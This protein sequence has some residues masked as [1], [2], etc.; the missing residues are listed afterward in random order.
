MKTI[1]IASLYIIGMFVYMIW[2]FG[3]K[4]TLDYLY[5]ELLKRDPDY[6]RM[7]EHAIKLAIFAAMLLVS[8]PWPI[9]VIMIPFEKKEP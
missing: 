6:E 2:R 3:E 7:P 5:E 4:G 8:L 9:R 1:I